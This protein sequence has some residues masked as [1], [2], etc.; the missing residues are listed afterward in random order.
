MEYEAFQDRQHPEDWRVETTDE[1]GG[2]YVNIFSGPE[3]R[4]RAE[5]YAA[6]K[7]EKR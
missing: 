4:R 5:E 3:A 2:C 1:D 6:W 7:S